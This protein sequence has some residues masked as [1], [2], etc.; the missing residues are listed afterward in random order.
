[1]LSAARQEY[2]R[3]F[4][5]PDEELLAFMSMGSNPAAYLLKLFPHI[6]K[7]HINDSIIDKVGLNHHLVLS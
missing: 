3:L 6:K 5:L 4:L 1:M 2:P 7:I